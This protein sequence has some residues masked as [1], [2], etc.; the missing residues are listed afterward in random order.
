MPAW[1]A[2]APTVADGTFFGGDITG[3]GGGQMGV[4][5]LVPADSTAGEEIPVWPKDHP[6]PFHK[7]IRKLMQLKPAE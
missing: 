7:P 3:G 6:T 1:N 4:L 2:Y 5:E